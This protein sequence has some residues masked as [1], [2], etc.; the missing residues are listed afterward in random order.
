MIERFG[1]SIRGTPAFAQGGAVSA[2]PHNPRPLGPRP[3]LQ[4]PVNRRPDGGVGRPWASP[5]AWPVAT[6]S[7]SRGRLESCSKPLTDGKPVV[8]NV[9][10]EP[11]L[12]LTG[13]GLIGHVLEGVKRRTAAFA[14]ERISSPVVGKPRPPAATG[15][16][17]QSVAWAL[18]MGE[19]TGRRGR[20]IASNGITTRRLNLAPRGVPYRS[21]G[22]PS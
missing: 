2:S 13:V 12:H 11:L 18:D 8:L 19:A 3:A 1:A 6:A 21:G 4:P 15:W 17:S 7:R 5:E 9:A 16:W 14:R 20:P 22:G 10:Y